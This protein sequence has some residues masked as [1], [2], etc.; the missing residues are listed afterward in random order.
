MVDLIEALPAGARVLD[1][2]AGAGSF[3]TGRTDLLIV[4]LD[5]E[6]RLERAPGAYVSADAARMPFA[7]ASFDLIISNHS[8]EHFPE[9][10]QTLRE[11][12]RTIKPAGVL[13]VAV[14][15]ASTLADH[16]YRWLARGGGHVNPFRGPEEVAGL[17]TRLTGLPHRSTRILFTSLS[18]LNARNFT[19]R[20]PRRMLLFA[21]G[22]ERFLAAFNW[23]LRFIDG[24]LGTRFSH[25]GWSFYFGNIE[26]PKTLEPWINVCIR[27]GS[28]CSEDFLMEAGAISPIPG[29]FDRYLCPEC[30][31]PNRLTRVNL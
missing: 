29:A 12:G 5:L 2:G 15:D 8:L 22:D 14:P 9:L 4:R 23:L 16:I 17:I 24:R 28:A 7:A 1:L 13:Y 30:G 19:S 3:R 31:A 26:L 27:C 25:Y 21:N 10:E 20:P 11:V 6:I 18:F